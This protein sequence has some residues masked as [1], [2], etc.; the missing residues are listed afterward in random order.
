MI[1]PKYNSAILYC[2]ACIQYYV[3]NKCNEVFDGNKDNGSSYTQQA[4]NRT[5]NRTAMMVGNIMSQAFSANYGVAIGLL[6]VYKKYNSPKSL[7]QY[8]KDV[9]NMLQ[10]QDAKDRN[11][12]IKLYMDDLLDRKVKVETTMVESNKLIDEILSDKELKHE[13]HDRFLSIFNIFSK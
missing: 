7:Y 8:V 12:K 10:M 3:G 5:Q 2:D 1:D 11:E 4:I 9:K 13:L 6:Y